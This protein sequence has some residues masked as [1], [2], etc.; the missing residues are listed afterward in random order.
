MAQL[1]LRNARPGLVVVVA[2]EGVG[3][4]AV[5]EGRVEREERPCLRDRA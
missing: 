2:V 3:R 1:L 5:A 4:G